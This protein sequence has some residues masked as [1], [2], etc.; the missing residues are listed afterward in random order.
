MKG[1]RLGVG[2]RGTY[3]HAGRGGLYV[4]E[5]LGHHAPAHEAPTPQPDHHPAAVSVG[6]AE[7]AEVSPTPFTP[8]LPEITITPG[9]TPHMVDVRAKKYGCLV[10][11]PLVVGG[12]FAF[13]ALAANLVLPAGL[14]AVAAAVLLHRADRRYAHQLSLYTSRLLLLLKT[15]PPWPAEAAQTCMQLREEGRFHPE[16]LHAIHYAAFRA[17]L[18]AIL[19]DGTITDLERQAIPQA[20]SLLGLPALDLQAAKLEAFRRHYLAAISDHELT[21]E[22]DARLQQFRN[23]LEIPAEALQEELAMLTD[24]REARRIRDG[25]LQQIAVDVALQ[26]GERCYHKT[27]ARLLEKRVLRSYV[28]NRVRQKEEGLVVAKEGSLYIT[29]KRLLLV[30][31]GA[32]S[33]PLRKVLDVDMETDA[34]QI[35]IKLDGRQRPIVLTVP[36]AI[37]TGA[38][39]ERA[40]REA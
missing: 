37:I 3:L 30:A 21:T 25:G 5:Y 13:L 20:T 10:F 23:A 11:A 22:E 7:P 12:I 26:D 16:H 8:P 40:G 39:I 14:L 17:L 32:T 15:P 33:F 35:T 18:E 6:T 27:R 24:L 4:R 34:K 31:D 1:L 28:V 9:P 2:P 29:S 19:E 36:D 38:V